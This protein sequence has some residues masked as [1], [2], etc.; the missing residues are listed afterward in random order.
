MTYAN[1][2]RLRAQPGRSAELVAILVRPK[3]GLREAGCMLYEVGGDQ[4]DSDGVHVVE[5]WESAEAHRASLR[6]DSVKAAITEAMPLLLPD[7][8]STGFEVAGSPLRF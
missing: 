7:L 2:G 3:E 8:S 5:L 4:D 1:V 6:L